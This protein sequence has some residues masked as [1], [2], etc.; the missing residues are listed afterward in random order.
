M[1]SIRL[2]VS[3]AAIHDMK[4]E[5]LDVANAYLNGTLEEK[6]FMRPPTNLANILESIIQKRGLSNVVGEKATRML[7]DF[8]DG[9]QICHLQKSLYDLRQSGRSWHMMLDKVLR[10]LGAIPTNADPCVY[11][12]G[13][14]EDAT[15]V[16]I[17][18]DDILIMP[19][20]SNRIKQFREKLCKEFEVKKLGN[21]GYCLGVEFEVEKSKITMHQR[22]YIL[23]LLKRFGM[24]NCNPIST[25]MDPQTKLVKPT[26]AEEV[27]NFPY[28]ELIGGLTYLAITTRPDISHAVSSLGQFNNCH[29]KVHWTAAN[30]VL[31][32]LRC[33]LNYG[34]V[35]TNCPD[36]VRGY[37]DADWANC[38]IDRR[39]YTG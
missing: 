37:A 5:Q 15:M 25:P 14:G 30:R 11:C 28:R 29:G 32:Y 31:R 16:V 2:L 26:T 34:L 8:R 9:K 18:V 38:A 3:L 6:V 19:R 39:S 1:S 20:D 35:Y 24:E 17:Y 4:I 13:R 10:K 27:K 33:T 21:V 23:D 22:R 12:V 7:E 36:P